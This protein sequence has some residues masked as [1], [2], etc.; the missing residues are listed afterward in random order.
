V[1]NEGDRISPKLTVGVTPWQGVTFYGTYAEGYRAPAITETLI[2]GAHPGPPLFDCD[3]DTVPDNLFCFVP[4]PDLLPETG[5][6][7]ELGVNLAFDEVLQPGDAFRLKAAVYQNDVEDYIDQVEYGDMVLYMG[8]VPVY[9]FLQYQNVAQARLRGAEVEATYDMGWMFMG[10]AGSLVRGEN[11]SDGG[12]LGSVPPD[13]L[14]ATVGFRTLENKL[15]FGGT[16]IGVAG[17][18]RVPEGGTPSDAYT[19]VNLFASYQPTDNLRFGASVENLFNETYRPY[20]DQ[21]NG[22]GTTFKLSV[23]GR[24]G[25]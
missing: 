20:L 5:K 17:Q 7:K 9:E 11:V 3:G 19:L 21:T 1:E 8:V 10:L 18:D 14:A 12:Y 23:T 22:K 13:K 24:I 25:G 15:A 2:S 6:T 16:V 4:N